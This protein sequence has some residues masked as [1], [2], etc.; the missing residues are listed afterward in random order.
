MPNGTLELCYDELGYEYKIP[1]Y[2]YTTPANVSTSNA[3]DKSEYAH[4]K[5]IV[6]TPL[7]LKVR[8]NPGD[9]N[10]GE[11]AALAPRTAS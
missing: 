9:C 8:I 1:E 3:I 5:T 11:C 2:C 7:K 6:G 4:K 10:L